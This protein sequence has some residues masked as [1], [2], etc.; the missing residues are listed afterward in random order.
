MPH[1]VLIVDDDAVLL[2]EAERALGEHHFSV[3]GCRSG[4]DALDTLQA[5][6]TPPDVIVLDRMMPGWDGI[7]T[8]K[9][10]RQEGYKGPIIFLTALDEIEERI[11]G[12]EVGADDYVVKPFSYHELA[13][14]IRARLKSTDGQITKVLVG[15]FSLDLIDNRAEINGEKV[16]LRPKEFKLLHFLL[17]NAS[18]VMSRESIL[19][20]VMGYNFDP[21]N[22][23]VDVHISRLRKHLK[24]SS[25]EDWAIVS[26]R[27]QGYAL[28]PVDT[29]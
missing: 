27:G 28:R 18:E 5:A 3:T 29:D 13:V 15:P 21:G 10:I 2:E 8:F 26:V 20:D 12:F 23:I 9:K 19:R 11:E 4:S 24:E 16:L 7:T 14:R 22:N 1:H 25:V 6:K 17:E